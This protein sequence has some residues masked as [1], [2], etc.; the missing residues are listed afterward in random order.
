MQS[1]PKLGFLVGRS[2]EDPSLA[3]LAQAPAC[4]QRHPEDLRNCPAVVV[5]DID[6]GVDIAVVVDKVVVVVPAEA[7]TGLVSV[8][9]TVVGQV[10]LVEDTDLVVVVDPKKHKSNQQLFQFLEL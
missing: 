1:G 8:E 6:L 10:G 3:R 5:E 4:R 2:A 9:D 7:D